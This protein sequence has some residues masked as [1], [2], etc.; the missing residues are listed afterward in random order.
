V[1][2][3]RWCV[4]ASCFPVRGA[5]ETMCDTR[6]I[7]PP[8]APASSETSISSI[9]EETF[10]RLRLT[11]DRN[12]ITFFT[13]SA[14]VTTQSRVSGKERS[15]TSNSL[16]ALETVT[17]AEE[18]ELKGLIRTST[19]FSASRPV[20]LPQPPGL[21]FQLQS[22]SYGLIQE[23]LYTSLYALVVQAILWNQT[24]SRPYYVFHT[25]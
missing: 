7:H 14:M 8:S 4:V 16:A 12:S 5:V 13:T 20:D 1:A 15:A 10:R 23:R 25:R 18:H 9:S 2:L 11:V 19:K 22:A 24:F 21:P 3:W 6:I 17:A